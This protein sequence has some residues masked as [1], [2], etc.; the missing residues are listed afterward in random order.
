MKKPFV[1]EPFSED[2]QYAESI[3]NI[4]NQLLRKTKRE[5]K[6]KDKTKNKNR[7]KEK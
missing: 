1:I 7:S 4:S 5:H 3:I 6:S 2:E